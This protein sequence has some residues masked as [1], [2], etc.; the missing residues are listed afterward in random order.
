MAS[1]PSSRFYSAKSS[2]TAKEAK[3]N[4]DRSKQ[5]DESL[6]KMENPPPTRRLLEAHPAVCELQFHFRVFCRQQQAIEFARSCAMPKKVFAYELPSLGSQG[7]RRY[8]AE[9]VF[10]FG[11][12]YVYDNACVV[13]SLH[14]VCVLCTC[15]HS[16][17]MSQVPA[18]PYACSSMKSNRHVYEVITE[19]TVCKLYFDVEFGLG[20]NPGVIGV[21]LL[22]VLIRYICYLIR[23]C[24][25]LAVNRNHIL[26]L[27]SRCVCVQG[28]VY[29]CMCVCGCLCWMWGQQV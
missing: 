14:A 19:D 20:Y 6:V 9:S 23:H 13:S 8:L 21:E 15:P 4:L 7:Q 25:G 26:D 11:Q 3:L 18:S 28:W 27:D 17:H 1:F 29:G 22:E 24:F 12:A 10:D 5:H 16:W 2:G